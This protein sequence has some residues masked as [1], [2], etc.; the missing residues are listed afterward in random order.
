MMPFGG[1]HDI[2][3]AYCLVAFW[4]RPGLGHYCSMLAVLAH[5]CCE[6]GEQDEL[7]THRAG[8]TVLVAAAAASFGC[9]P[10]GRQIPNMSELGGA[11]MDSYTPI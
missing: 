8:L 6:L 10:E 2:V 3:H 5:M 1:K 11:Q 4:A 9:I 7:V